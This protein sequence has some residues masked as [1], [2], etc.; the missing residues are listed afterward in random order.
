MKDI[1]FD[2]QLR[3]SACKILEVSENAGKEEL[4]KA[5]RKVS[6]KCHPDRNLNDVDANKKFILLKCAYEFLV[7]AKP[8]RMLLEEINFWISVSND[9]KYNLENQWGYFL[10]WKEK[11]FDLKESNQNINSNRYSCI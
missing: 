9:N 11:Y 1:S 3:R 4:K 10:W 5:Y 2:L 8:C 6:L 7:E